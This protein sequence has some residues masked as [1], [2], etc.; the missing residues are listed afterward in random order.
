MRFLPQQILWRRKNISK[1]WHSGKL[2]GGF[3]ALSGVFILT[4]PIPIVVNSFAQF[5][6]NRL[7][8]NEVSLIKQEDKSENE[9]NEGRAQEEGADQADRRGQADRPEVLPHTGA[10][11][12][13]FFF[14]F[15][16]WLTLVLL[17]AFLFWL[18]S[19]D[20]GTL[21]H[22]FQEL[23]CA[24]LVM[25]MLQFKATVFFQTVFSQTV[26]SKLYFCKLFFWSVPDFCIEYILKI[27]KIR[28]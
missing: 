6:K 18:T 24:A 7:W 19:W 27:G 16:F 1:F 21:C 20:M 25:L 17:F 3:C 22:L 10:S 9:K 4:L 23:P 5:Y 28:Y 14:L 11:S 2:I 26:F 12:D 8:R 15:S 13:F